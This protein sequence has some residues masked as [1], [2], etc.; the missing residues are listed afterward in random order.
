MAKFR[1]ERWNLGDILPAHDGKEF[2]SLMKSLENNVKKF[3]SYRKILNPEMPAEKLLDIIKLLEKISETSGKIGAYPALWFAMNT[4]NQEARAFKD[5]VNNKLTELGNKLLFFPLWF[6]SLSDKWA[7]K[8]IKRAGHYRYYLESV[9]L[10]K[11]YTLSE[12]EEKIINI[13]STSGTE[14]LNS[15]YDIITNSFKFDMKFGKRTKAM[16]QEE[17]KVYTRSADKNLRENSYSAI[18][19]RYCE[20]RDALGEIYKNIL[21]DWKNEG[22]KLRGYKSY[23]SPRN[24]GNDISDKAI[25]T[26]LD[27]CRKNTRLFQRYFR[28]KA[29]LIGMKTLRRYDIYAPLQKTEKK[30]TFP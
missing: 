23:V 2:N 10:T 14:A 20:N 7:G 18:L 17:I 5:K 1:Q 9:R 8:F 22:I 25:K 15:L 28:L 29:K 13:K 3:E 11:K 24:I 4:K 19:A 6:K 12:P 27:V 26:M 21:T 16:N 30:Y